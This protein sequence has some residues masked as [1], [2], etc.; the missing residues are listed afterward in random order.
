MNDPHDNSQ[1]D[2]RVLAA[3]LLVE[4]DDKQAEMED[5]AD[6]IAEATGMDLDVMRMEVG[7]FRDWLYIAFQEVFG[8]N[9]E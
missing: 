5:I 1:M 3:A 7:K 8:G 2:K 9:D 6:R 4:F